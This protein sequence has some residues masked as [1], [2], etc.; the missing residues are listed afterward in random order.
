MAVDSV[1]AMFAEKADEVLHA[2]WINRALN[3]E[4]LRR[5]AAS[6]E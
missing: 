2:A 1:D 5:K 4:D 6:P 3:V